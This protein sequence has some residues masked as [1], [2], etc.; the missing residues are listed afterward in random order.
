MGAADPMLAALDAA[1]F[2]VTDARRAVAD[3]I[4]RREGPFTAAD[5]IDDARASH[6]GIG[7]ATVFRAIDAFMELNV[8]ERIDLPS[9]DHAYVACDPAHHHHVVCERCGR[10]T[11]IDDRGVRDIVRAIERRTGYAID[12]H[13]LELF[14]RCASCASA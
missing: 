6:L 5:L 4:A 3:L 12:R 7:R 10:T 14:G 11:E 2:R 8:V 1:G 13:R 9:G